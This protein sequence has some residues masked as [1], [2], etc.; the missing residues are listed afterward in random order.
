M[1]EIS[2]VVGIP[3]NVLNEKELTGLMH[4]YVSNDVMNI[5]YM[6]S[7]A[8]LKSVVMM[9]TVR[10][11]I[12]KADVIL[13]AERAILSRSGKKKERDMVTYESLLY[14]L[15]HHNIIKSVY[16][17][18]AE[19]KN[20]QLFEQI[21]LQSRK[22]DITIYGVR[23]LD[24]QYSDDSIINEINSTVPD[25]L[26]LAMDSPKLEN[27]IA[28]HRPK[29][30][31]KMCIALGDILDVI[32]KENAEPSAFIK[33]IGLEKLYYFIRKKYAESKK[34]ER[35]L[36][37]ILAEYNKKQGSEEHEYSADKEPFI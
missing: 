8:T 22:S 27:W 33:N 17:L 11:A 26:I 21:L 15:R 23:S 18:G 20:T 12:C 1:G 37:S 31:A 2:N 32:V 25:A 28:S 36:N 9:P 5:V 6:V 24:E 19:Q 16:I 34:N 29:I 30:N 4:S 7:V 35:I 3:F 13:P 10:D 14:I